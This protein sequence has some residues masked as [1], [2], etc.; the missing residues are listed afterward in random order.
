MSNRTIKAIVPTA[1]ILILLL[2]GYVWHTGLFSTAPPDKITIGT[3]LI[4][5]NGL[6]FVAKSQGFDKHHGLDLTIKPYPTGRDAAREVRAG[7][8]EFACCAEFVLVNEIFT[9]ADN[10]RC[11]ATVSS[12][13]IHSLI[14]RRDKGI[15][16]PEDLRGKTIG[17]PLGTSAEFY[18]ARFLA[19]NKIPWKEVTIVDVNLP[20][21]AKTLSQ[22]KMDAVLAWAPV[23]GEIMNIMGTGAVEWPAQEGQDFY[24]LLVS[25]E[26]VIKNRKPSLEKLFRALNQAA[27]FIRQQPAA[28]GAIMS[29]WTKEPLSDLQTGKYP[30]RHELALDQG[31]LLAMEDQARWMINNKLTNRTQVPNYLNYI[32]PKALLKVD[33]KGV[34]LVLPGKTSLK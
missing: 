17:A 20:E 3:N 19:F 16:R 6:M 9:G 4:G 34:R 30:I 10:L 1:I 22:G 26:A 5:M 23:T 25:R 8:L 21:L 14:A 7:R 18:L 27:D 15:A 29:Q 31:L 11:L 12:G 32:D 2:S 24:W 33:P 28:A 13:D